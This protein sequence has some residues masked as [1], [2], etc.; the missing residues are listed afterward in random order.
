M[1]PLAI[2]L[3]VGMSGCSLLQVD[4]DL[5]ETCVTFLDQEVPGVHPG[6]TFV[7]TFVADEFKLPDGF[8]KLD[9][10]ITE[11]RA[12]LHLTGGPETFAFLDG[13]T[14]E[15]ADSNGVLDPMMLIACQGGDCRSDT[16]I[17]EIRVQTPENIIDYARNA[18]P[19]FTIT[20]VGN[21]PAT[22]WRTDV[23]VCLT[24]HASIKI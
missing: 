7:K 15:V 23:Q 17:T 10:V 3:L 8:I 1:R 9:A 22:A 2:L 16:N 12:V 5:P 6:E 19:V 11:A 24:G 13:I 18:A 4:A 20:M 21:L 14:V